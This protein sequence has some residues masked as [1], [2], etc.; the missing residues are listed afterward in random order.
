MQVEQ[1]RCD[2]NQHSPHEMHLRHTLPRRREQDF[3]LEELLE[4]E[5]ILQE[6]RNQNQKLVDL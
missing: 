6:C 5:D 1:D 3:T 2:S 4:D